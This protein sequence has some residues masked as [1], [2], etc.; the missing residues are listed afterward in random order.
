MTDAIKEPIP[1]QIY[2]FE[3][4]G[5][6]IRRCV[7]DVTPWDTVVMSSAFGVASTTMSKAD[8]R[9]WVSHATLVSGGEDGE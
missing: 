7:L 9:L 8:W 5:Q 3:E 2:E 4:Y 1:G 6:T